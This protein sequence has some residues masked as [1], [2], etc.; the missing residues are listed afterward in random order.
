MKKEE[1]RRLQQE[2]RERFIAIARFILGDTNDKPENINNWINGRSRVIDW[3]K[4]LG[5]RYLKEAGTEFFINLQPN[6][7]KRI[8]QE[9]PATIICLPS[10]C[11]KLGI[12]RPT[13][14]LQWAG[15]FKSKTI[16]YDVYSIADVLDLLIETEANDAY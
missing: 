14:I 13:P 16:Y 12:T 15:N 10:D 3:R 4:A 11:N 9:Y 7:R 6:K 2:Y 1:K 8:L 5:K